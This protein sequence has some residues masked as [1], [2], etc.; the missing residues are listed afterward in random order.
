MV[1]KCLSVAPEYAMQFV[2]GTKRIEYRTWSTTYRGPLLICA[3]AKP[4]P[5]CISGR[6]VILAELYNIDKC[7]DGVYM[8]RLRNFE[9]I[10]PF[11]VKGKQR[12][13][14]IEADLH[15]LK[16]RAA[17]RRLPPAYQHLISQAV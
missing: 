16:H 15:K 13:F 10:E 14:E 7:D 3:T 17:T 9:F 8:W 1:Y 2:R 6:A 5:G 11:A 4:T 12:I